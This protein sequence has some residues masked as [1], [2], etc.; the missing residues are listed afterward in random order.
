MEEIQSKPRRSRRL[1]SQPSLTPETKL[2]RTNRTHLTGSK[3]PGLVGTSVPTSPETPV[4]P[5]IFG[6]PTST[7]EI[8]QPQEDIRND[9]SVMVNTSIP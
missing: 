3:S 1:T 8:P 2:F 5:M 9:P 4:T 7:K 6:I